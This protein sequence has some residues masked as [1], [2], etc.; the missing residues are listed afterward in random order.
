MG[1]CPSEET[2]QS[3]RNT[4][5]PPCLLS[6]L[7]RNSRPWQFVGSMR[8]RVGATLSVQHWCPLVPQWSRPGHGHPRSAHEIPFKPVDPGTPIN[9]ILRFHRLHW[10]SFFLN[11]MNI[12]VRA[13]SLISGAWEYHGVS[14]CHVG[15]G[16]NSR[17]WR[18]HSN[19][20]IF[21]N[22]LMSMRLSGSP[23]GFASKHIGQPENPVMYISPFSPFDCHFFRPAHTIP[24]PQIEVFFWSP[25]H[26]WSTLPAVWGSLWTSLKAWKP[27][28]LEVSED[29]ARKWS[30]VQT[31]EA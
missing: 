9:G 27:P 15:M 5:W 1:G 17:L 6:F 14:R 26:S 4:F 7:L 2:N 21:E 12:F 20:P 19:Q 24:A 31:W 11:T 30:A 8:P 29:L 28:S 22:A 25:F 23:S 16:K 10:N 13:W 3:F 18:L